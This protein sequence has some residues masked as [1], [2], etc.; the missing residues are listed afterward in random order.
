M[1]SF[2]N[3]TALMLDNQLPPSSHFC[4]PDDPNSERKLMYTAA[5]DVIASK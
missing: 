1:Q 4:I 3:T 5:G 2:C